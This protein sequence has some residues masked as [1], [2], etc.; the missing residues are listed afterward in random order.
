MKEAREITKGTLNNRQVKFFEVWE[1][2]ER[3]WHFVAKYA[4]P[5]KV[6]NKNLV[7]WAEE[8]GE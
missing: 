8:K 3:T 1:M 4:A 5:V 7:A 2:R 6:A